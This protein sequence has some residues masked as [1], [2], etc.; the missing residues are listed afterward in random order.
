MFNRFSSRRSV[1]HSTKGMVASSQPLASAAGVRIL[2][3][4]GN[5]VEAAVA[6]LAALC[7]TEPPSTGVG[8]DCFMLFYNKNDEKVHG[9]N[10]CGRSPKKL[11][12]DLV[13]KHDK[14]DGPRLSLESVHSITVPGAVAGWLD[15]IELWGSGNVSLADIFEPAIELAES[16]FAVSEVSADLWR[17]G[18]E[19]LIKQSGAN[20]SVFLNADGLFVE[21]GQVFTNKPLAKVFRKIASEGKDGFYKGDVA[22]KIVAKVQLMGGVLELDD[23]ASHKSQRVDPISIEF[24]GKH[25]WEI[26]PNGQGIVALF[27]LGYIRE[28]AKQKL[29]DLDK[30]EH[31]SPEYLNLLIEAVKLGFY[32]SEH[33]VTDLEFHP[34]IDIPKVLSA[35]NL[36][37]RSKLIRPDRILAREHIDA[38]PDPMYKC[39]TV[40]FTVTDKDGN[41][42]SFINSVFSLFG[43]GIIPDDYGFSLQSRGANFNLSEKAINSLEGGKRPYHTIIPSL[44]TEKSDDLSDKLYASVACMGG[45]AQPQAHVQIFLNLVLFGFSPQEAV[46][47]PRFCLE[48]NEEFRHLDVGKGS[49]GPIST[50]KT[51]VRLEEG[52]AAETVAAL[53]KMGHLVDTV[54]GFARDVFGRAQCIKNISQSGRVVWAAG[55]DQRGDGAAIPQI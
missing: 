45:W 7:V 34:E 40:Y 8:G 36:A 3:K 55:S 31:N 22:E 37:E 49:F 53:E 39:D 15:A 16:G 4:G 6:V 52:I 54:S 1:V 51:I 18:L 17:Q 42:C 28:L 20:A 13:K 26:P 48:P 9:L 32:D 47:A 11:S 27:A 19:K 41:A 21:Q 44:I 24:N 30:L 29:I 35:E 25:L 2:E 14:S 46:D 50:P 23:L 10:G 5:S 38:A 33:C 12:I 43:S